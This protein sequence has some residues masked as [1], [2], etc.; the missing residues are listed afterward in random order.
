VVI[1][2]PAGIVHTFVKPSTTKM[3]P[4]CY[5]MVVPTS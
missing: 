3:Q 4:T 1:V 2:H 5:R